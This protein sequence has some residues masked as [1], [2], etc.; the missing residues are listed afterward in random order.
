MVECI[1]KHSPHVLAVELNRGLHDTLADKGICERLYHRNF[2][3]IQPHNRYNISHN[4]PAE[5]P[6]V[7]RVVMCP[8]KNSEA[9]IHHAQ[10]FLQGGGRLAALVQEQNIDPDNWPT[11]RRTK[12]RFQMGGKELPCGII[13]L[14]CPHDRI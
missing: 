5:I 2:L 12:T 4:I 3:D 14:E 9:H 7:D 11:Y 6:M 8:P 10:K 1:L 13:T